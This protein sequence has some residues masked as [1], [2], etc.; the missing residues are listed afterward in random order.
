MLSSLSGK[1]HVP[2]RNLVVAKEV[3]QTTGEA[4]LHSGAGRHT[5]TEGHIAS[6]G[7]VETLD[8]NTQ[9]LEFL[10]DTID[11]TCPRSLGA[12]RVAEL[13]VHT[14]FQID[15]VCH[16]GIFRTIDT[17]LGGDTLVNCTGEYESSVIVGVLT[18]QVNTS[19]RGVN[20][21]C[22]SVKVLDE[23]ASYKFNVNHNCSSVL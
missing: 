7:N 1:Y 11:I 10:G 19:R 17:H 5:G 20:I 21:T 6:K 9:L 8:G 18:N 16:Y 14:V 22:L 23:A 15:G 3:V 4:A 12:C 2:L 13:E